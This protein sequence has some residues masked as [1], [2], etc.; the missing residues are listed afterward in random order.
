VQ[1]Q[2][3]FS[4]RLDLDVDGASPNRVE[5]VETRALPAG[6]A[7]AHGGGFVTTARVLATEDSARRQLDFHTSRRWRVVNPASR[8]GLGV[9]A[10]YEL[11]PGT[12]ADALMAEASAVRRRAG[13]VGAHLWATAYADS[14]RY[15]AGD[16]PNQSAG[17]N[18]L[19]KWSAANRPLAASDVVLWYT[20]G[21]THTPR[22]EDW[23]VMPVHEAGFELVPVGFFTRNPV[24][25][26]P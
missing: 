11:R 15:A 21:V 18:G 24:L 26:R 8:G 6:P 23:P 10:S 1:H 19:A 5:E 20:L 25:A 13:F 22:P 12:N 4:Y 7:N 2:H 14:E 17:G 9:S 3:L 16:Y